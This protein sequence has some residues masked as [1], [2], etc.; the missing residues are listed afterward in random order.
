MEHELSSIA[1]A[2]EQA[3]ARLGTGNAATEMGALEF[4]AKELRDGLD[5]V[6]DALSDL[7]DAV[8]EHGMEKP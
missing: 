1:D 7:A 3:A 8:R 6:A 2:I 4:V 5:K